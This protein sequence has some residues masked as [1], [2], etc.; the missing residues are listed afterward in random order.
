[1]RISRFAN[2]FV[3]V[4]GVILP[5]VAL[6]V[7]LTFNMLRSTLFNPLPTHLHAVLI[8]LVPLA[9]ARLAMALA[10]G[11]PLPPRWLRLHAFTLG[12]SVYYSL[13]FL[14][15]TPIAAVAV[16]FYGIGLLPLAP[17][18][19][20]IAGLLGRFRLPRER[21]LPPLWRGALLAMACIVLFDLPAIS[22]RIGLHLATAESRTVQLHGMRWLRIA[23]S[24]ELMLRHCY[25]RDNPASLVGALLDFDRRVDPGGARTVFYRVT[26]TPFNSHPAPQLHGRDWD[27]MFQD[28]GGDDVGGRAATLHLASSSMNGSLDPD[29]ALGYLEW[30]MIVRNDGNAADEARATLRLPPGAVVSRVTLWIDGEEREAAFG[31]RAQVRK[32]YQQVVQA[33]RDPVL[34]TTAGAGR[35]LMQMFP[36]PA[37]GM[38]KVRIGIS[39]PLLLRSAGRADL[40]MPSFAEHNFAIAP[41]L[42]HAVWVE[43]PQA[44]PIRGNLAEP[45]ALQAPGTIGFARDSAAN[46]AWS[47]DS[48]GGGTVQQ[49]LRTVPPS[50]PRRIALVIDGS[51]SMAPLRAQ[52]TKVVDALPPDSELGI[53]FADDEAPTVFV[54]DRGDA[55]RTLRFLRGLEYQG[56]RGNG[57]ALAHAWDWTAQG[58]GGA[59]VWV[60]GPQAVLTETAEPMLQRY[61]RRPDQV[62][63]Y[64]LEAVGGANLLAKAFD[65]TVPVTQVARL[66]SAGDDLVRLLQDWQRPALQAERKRAPAL[67][68]F[69]EKPLKTS[70]HAARLWAFDEVARLMGSSQDKAAALA[71]RYQLVTPVTGAVVLETRAQYDAAGLEPVPPG[72]V[73]T[74]P[75][76]ETWAM[77]LVALLLLALRYRQRGWYPGQLA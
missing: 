66:G 70:E 48:K 7:E 34:V 26:G 53:V 47:S 24:D 41:G 15:I 10:N 31:P 36:V 27:S 18:L 44:P 76:P 55:L 43:A 1:M 39:M 52:L 12:I 45:T 23:G 6:T 8:A 25:A 49:H 32:A 4:F 77:L 33:N 71:Q 61:Q 3:V 50:A 69:P 54:H 40:Q 38:M 5:V 65:G 2:A 16:L 57:A 67:A 63:L 37:H 56:G 58:Q 30:T 51:R 28:R 9:N 59:I 35:V 72:S 17:L 46:A 64:D 20:L 42:R 19:S 73:P 22:T 60:H 21:S 68:Q 74:V 11:T 29:A 62:R 75:E 14:P 13:Q